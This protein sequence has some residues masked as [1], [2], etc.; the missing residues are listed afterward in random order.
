MRHSPQ[1]V[2]QPIKHLIMTTPILVMRAL[3][4]TSV[5]EA[6]HNAAP[7]CLFIGNAMISLPTLTY[8]TCTENPVK[9][10]DPSHLVALRAARRPLSPPPSSRAAGCGRKRRWLGTRPRASRET[11]CSAP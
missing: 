5:D 6:K 2:M 4:M 11:R 7:I 8:T 1:L 10:I 3:T 9:D